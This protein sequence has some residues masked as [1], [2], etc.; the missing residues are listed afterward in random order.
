MKEQY[1]EPEIEIICLNN[2]DIITE[3]DDD[4]GHVTPA[5]PDMP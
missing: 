4:L 3:S 5:N 2:A 1:R